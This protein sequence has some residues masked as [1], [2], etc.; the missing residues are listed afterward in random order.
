[1]GIPHYLQAIGYTNRKLALTK[2]IG[3]AF[4]LLGH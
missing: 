3:F 4:G 1:V 2:A